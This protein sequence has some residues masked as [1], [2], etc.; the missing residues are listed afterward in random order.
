MKTIKFDQRAV[1]LITDGIVRPIKNS[2]GF[3]KTL[4]VLINKDI[5][6]IFKNEG[7]LS[8]SGFHKWKPFSP[9]TL[10]TIDGKWAHRPGTDKSKTRKYSARSKLLQAS[11]LFRKSFGILWLKNKSVKVGTIHKLAKDI[12]SNPKREV[13]KTNARVIGRYRDLFFRWVDKGIKF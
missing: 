13:I 9:R 4:G 5:S 6:I 3:F 10:K 7:A 1:K 2:R 11:G 12:M 8:G